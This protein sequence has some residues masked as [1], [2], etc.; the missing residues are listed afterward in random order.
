MRVRVGLVFLLAAMFLMPAR[1]EDL[2]T[3]NTN[4]LDHF[5]S[6]AQ[7]TNRP[8]TVVSFGDSMANSYASVTFSVINMMAQN[9]GIAGYSLNNYDNATLANLTNG[10]QLVTGPTPLW[11]SDYYQLPPGGTVWWENQAAVGGVYSDRVGVFWVAQP[12]GGQMTFSVSTQAGAWTPLLTLNG[13]AA[14]PTGHYTNVV[15]TADFHRI[16]VD[17]VTGTNDVIGPQL[18]LQ[19]TGGVHVVFMDKAAIALSDVTNVSAAIRVPI[20]AA[21]SPDLLI[22]H[23][24]EDGTIVTSNALIDCE[25]WWSNAA[26]SCNVIYIGTLYTSSDTNLTANATVDQNRLV[27]YTAQQFHRAYCDLMNPSIS[28]SWMA[29]QGYMSDGVHVTEAG[30]Q[31][32]AGFLWYEFGF[33]A[34]GVGSPSPSASFTASPTNGV[35]PVLVS[36][37]DTSSASVSNRFWN[38]GDGTTT[39][40]PT[41]FIRHPYATS[42][43]YTVTEIVSIP[44]GSLT[45][46]QVNCITLKPPPPSANFSA[47]PVNGVTPVIVTFTDASS[48]IITN[49]FWDL[50]DGNTT[51]TPTASMQHTYVTPGSYP[52]TEIVVGPG[53]AGIK[54][55]ANYITVL[56]TVQGSEYQAWQSKYFNCTNCPQAQMSANAD[57][58]GQNNLFKFTAGLDPTNLAS[59]FVLNAARVSNQ[60][61][62]VNILFNPAATG[63]IYTPQFCTNLLGG[64]WLPLT[65]GTGPATNGSQIAI[66][67]TNAVG[68]QKFYRIDIT[69]P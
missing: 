4:T 41:G 8:V 9:L 36:F 20:F 33:S 28:F 16:R 58:T 25:Q 42:G 21:L 57:G 11:F 64:A 22:W 54:T 35:A 17:G 62:W 40:A 18:L 66:T 55:R 45:N 65:T 39:N 51:N 5:W 2:S 26:P 53:G 34:L 44:G 38:F 60:P 46:T 15:L 24:R 23:M 1:A 61:A 13:V 69:L 29:S 50:G 43:V 6:A 68:P 63:R 47:T 30:G 52:V 48:G 49:W 14:V 27:R 59:V 19:T 12:Q 56:S 37:T 67:D 7:A 32:L 31:Y 3:I 10:A